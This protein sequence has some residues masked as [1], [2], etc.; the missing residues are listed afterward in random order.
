MEKFVGKF[1]V[2]SIQKYSSNVMEKCLEKGASDI[3][4]KFSDEVCLYT[5]ALGNN[6]IFKFFRFNEKL[7]W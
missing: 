5:R 3:I 4:D 2:L 6:K 7:F 1:Y